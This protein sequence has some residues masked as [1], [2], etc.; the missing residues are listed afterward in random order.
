MKF[1][2]LLSG[3]MNYILM[4]VKDQD[5]V[6]KSVSNISDEDNDEVLEDLS[7]NQLEEENVNS[8]MNNE[9][10]VRSNKLSASSKFHF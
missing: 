4:F 7:L 2:Y 6:R 3:T 1:T 8:A 5:K 10:E 9:M